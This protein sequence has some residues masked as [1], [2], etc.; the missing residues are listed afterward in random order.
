[1][2]V[3]KLPIEPLLKQFLQQRVQTTSIQLQ[4]NAL[5]NHFSES[6]SDRHFLEYLIR[7]EQTVNPGS[8]V[9]NQIQRQSHWIRHGVNHLLNCRDPLAIKLNRCLENDGPY[10]V[11][12]LGLR[13]WSTLLHGSDAEHFPIWSEDLEIGLARL[14]LL[15]PLRESSKGKRYSR[16]VSALERLALLDPRATLSSLVDF[17][18]RVAQMRGRELFSDQRISLNPLDLIPDLVRHIRIRYPLRKRL[19][20]QG[21]QLTSGKDEF[22]SALEKGED[23]LVTGWRIPLPWLERLWRDSDPEKVLEEFWNAASLQSLPRPLPVRILHLRDPKRFPRWEEPERRMLALLDDGLMDFSQ[24]EESYLLFREALESLGQTFR[25]HPL[26]W[27]D[28]AMQILEQHASRRAEYFEDR[29]RFRGFCRDSFT[30]LTELESNNSLEWMNQQRERYQFCVRDPIREL[31]LLLTE[32]YIEPVLRKGWGWDLEVEP[33][34]GRAISSILKNDYGQ[35]VPYQPTMGIHF[36]RSSHPSKQ[37]DVQWFVR[38]DDSGMTFGFHLGRKARESGKLFRQHIQ[39]YGDL[40]FRNLARNG[41]TKQCAFSGEDHQPILM[42][43]AN[44]LRAWASE[45]TLFAEVHV[46]KNQSLLREDDLVGEIILTFDRLLPLFVC[47]I[48]AEPAPFL[49]KRLGSGEPSEFDSESF[50]RETF[51]PPSWLERALHLLDLKKQLILQGVPGTGKTHVARLLARLLTGDHPHRVRLVQFHPAYSYEEFVEGIKART[52]EV[53]GKHEITYPVEEGVLCEVVTEALKVPSEPYVL[54]IDEINRGNLPRIFG[55]LLYLLEYRNQEVSLPY[56]RRLFRLPANLYLIGTMNRS[57]RSVALVD[58]ALR[59]RFSFLD[60]PPDA[61]VLA[62][63]LEKHLPH[64]SHGE[65]EAFG[66]KVVSLFETLN[67]KLEKDLGSNF[68][69]GHS[70]FMVPNLDEDRLRVVWEHHIWPLL[71]EFFAGQPHRLAGYDLD[72]LRKSKR[73]LRR[74]ENQN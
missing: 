45:K 21:K 36:F 42:Q 5:S 49:K 69:V 67:E 51:L 41:A 3:P 56:S 53:N 23:A 19:K 1:M 52:I 62:T 4:E 47:A 72:T 73:P 65:E 58:Q 64:A 25:I 18:Q 8:L 39:Q 54:L 38:V 2:K 16:V 70:Y 63:W 50:R 9:R 46:E 17:L 13:Y 40:L 15:T 34:A 24:P 7:L 48:E 12:G 44:A 66:Q 14:G 71:E 27:H 33:R 61:R 37:T 35:S 20:E 60:M 57:D 10:F 55:E 30:F 68:Q 74:S 29:S 31:C 22:Q 59:R 43:D 28:L 6:A 11:P 32:R 26:E